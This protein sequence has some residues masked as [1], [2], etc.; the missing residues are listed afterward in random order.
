MFL[1]LKSKLPCGL[2]ELG[3]S[4]VRPAVVWPVT[5]GRM[6]CLCRMSPRRESHGCSAVEAGPGAIRIHQRYLK[7]LQKNIDTELESKSK[8]Y[9]FEIVLSKI[10]TRQQHFKCNFR[11]HWILPFNTS[12]RIDSRTLSWIKNKFQSCQQMAGII[13]MYKC[14]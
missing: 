12:V 14:C 2:L 1:P 13:C 8:S 11:W 9:T 3:V 5:E 4:H 7:G 6:S 10:V